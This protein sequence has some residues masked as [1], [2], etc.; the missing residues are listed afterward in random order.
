MAPKISEAYNSKHVFVTHESGG[1]L[2]VALLHLSLTCLP[3]AVRWPAGFFS[4]QRQML[5]RTR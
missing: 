2:G 3:G 1:G 4:G 5:M